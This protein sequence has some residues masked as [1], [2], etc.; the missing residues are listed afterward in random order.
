MVVAILVSLMLFGCTS[1]PIN[2]PQSGQA[3][4]PDQPDDAE[5]QQT[6]VVPEDLGVNCTSY[7]GTDYSLCTFEYP[8]AVDKHVECIVYTGVRYSGTSE[9]LSCDW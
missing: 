8:A 6:Q 9:M 3:I 1:K 2:E 4:Q 5:V 7:S